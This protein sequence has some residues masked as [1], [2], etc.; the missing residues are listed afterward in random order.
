MNEL[1]GWYGYDSVERMDL[2]KG[3]RAAVLHSYQAAAAAA[4]AA[5]AAAAAAAVVTTATSTSATTI[6][7]ITTAITKPTM[8]QRGGCISQ[9]SISLYNHHRGMDSSSPDID[10][11]REN[12]K[13]PQ[14]M[15]KPAGD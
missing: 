5:N 7:P 15:T 3:A 12:S 14:M 9:N 1:L 10:S 8:L 2:S 13:S 4:L 11:S 6:T